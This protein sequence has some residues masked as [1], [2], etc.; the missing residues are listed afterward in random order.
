MND[1]ARYAGYP[2][3]ERKSVFHALNQKAA[4]RNA[5]KEI[6]LTY[7]TS[8]ML[9]AHIGNGISVAAHPQGKVI[10][11]N[12][13]LHGDGPLSLA[14]AGAL[15]S[16]ALIDLCYN[17]DSTKA[18]ITRD[19][20]SQGGLKGYVN[21]TDTS[22]TEAALH[23][24]D[25]SAIKLREAMSYQ[26]SKEIGAMATVLTGNVD[27]IGLT[28]EFATLKPLTDFIIS[29]ISWIGDVLLYPGDAELQALNAGTLRVL[30]KEESPKVYR[31]LKEK[32]VNYD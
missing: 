29:Q 1:I 13:G 5:A 12:N 7:D 24:K 17:Q 10:G 6:N 8:N 11:V 4:A 32:G 31:E 26:S 28:G 20:P 25:S 2:G 30:R 14:R 22:P 3:I 16:S 9:V 27:A 21:V 23:N 19:I 15:P 18:N